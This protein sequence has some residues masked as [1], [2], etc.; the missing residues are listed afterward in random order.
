MDEHAMQKRFHAEDQKAGVY[1]GCDRHQQ[2][3]N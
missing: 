3:G 2:R 1:G